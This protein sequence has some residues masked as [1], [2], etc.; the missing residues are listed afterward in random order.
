MA[1]L[2]RL[3]AAM[4]GAEERVRKGAPTARRSEDVDNSTDN[5]GVS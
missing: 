1:Q 2:V 5:M 3:N 4:R